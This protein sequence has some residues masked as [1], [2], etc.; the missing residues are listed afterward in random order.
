MKLKQLP[1]DFQ[2]EEL[3]DV[4]HGG[5]GSFAFYSLEK[6]GWSTPDALAAVRKRWK[7]DLRRVSFG[8]LK[9]RHA[10]TLQYFTIFHGPQRNLT[11]QELTVRYL[12]MT[13]APYTSKE[14]RANRFQIVLRNINEDDV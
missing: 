2:V 12:G 13:D 6:R 4:L 9:D 1:D 8:G 3:T 5:A 10:R 7:I 11:H 14:I